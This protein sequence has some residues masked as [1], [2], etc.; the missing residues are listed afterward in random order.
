MS[1]RIH[2]VPP[3]PTADPPLFR[4]LTDL[5]GKLAIPPVVLLTAA[6]F[7]NGWSHRGAPYGNAGYTKNRGA[8]HLTGVI[9]SGI[10][11]LA[12]YQLPEGFRP[13]AIICFAVATDA[14]YGSLEIDTSGYLT[15]IAGGTALFALDGVVFRTV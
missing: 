10:L 11:G 9:A 15:P 7:S 3:P 12:A 5:R 2:T 4:F 14:G 8:V 1:H 6:D 13:P